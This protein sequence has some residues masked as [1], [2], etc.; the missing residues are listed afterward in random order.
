MHVFSS[1]LIGFLLNGLNSA[2]FVDYQSIFTHKKNG[3]WT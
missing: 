2:Q 3:L 1:I